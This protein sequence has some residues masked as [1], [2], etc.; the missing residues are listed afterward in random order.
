MFDKISP[1][2]TTHWLIL[3]NV[4]GLVWYGGLLWVFGFPGSLDAI[5]LGGLD[6]RSYLAAGQQIFGRETDFMMYDALRFRP[7][8]F[9]FILAL[10]YSAGPFWV[11]LFQCCCWFLWLNTLFLAGTKLMRGHKLIPFFISLFALTNAGLVGISLHALSEVFSMALLG[12]LLLIVARKNHPIQEQAGWLVFLSALLTVIRPVF[13]LLTLFFIILFLIKT[14]KEER[15]ALLRKAG[16]FLA[17]LLPVW[18]QMALM[19]VHY[20]EVFISEIGAHTFRN[21]LAAQVLMQDR[22]LPL[23]EARDAVWAMTQPE[24]YRYLLGEAFISIHIWFSNLLAS[25][26]TPS[27]FVNYPE[28]HNLLTKYSLY[29]N[30]FSALL[31]FLSL[32]FTGWIHL[33]RTKW[34]DLR[35]LILLFVTASIWLT[36]GISFGEG[37]RLLMPAL[38]AQLLLLLYTLHFLVY[39]KS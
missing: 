37:D 7:F 29:W 27:W 2:K 33:R 3:L 23:E 38:S 9:S 6:A 18:I 31:F 32:L 10:L 17:A 16:L 20:G 28:Y 14:L 13:L 19:Y 11:W 34:P 24:L 4:L 36:A 39:E 22:S 5:L 12:I 25:F 21:H 15:T 26:N 8:L 1:R 30:R 35:L